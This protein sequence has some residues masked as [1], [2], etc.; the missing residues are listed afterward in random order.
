MCL[1]LQ[2]IFF[3]IGSRCAGLIGV[4]VVVGVHRL[5]ITAKLEGERA[6]GGFLCVGRWSSVHKEIFVLATSS[7]MV[8]EM[9]PVSDAVRP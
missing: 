2:C 5:W 6:G 9:L 7:G 8:L 1:F 3:G 4:F